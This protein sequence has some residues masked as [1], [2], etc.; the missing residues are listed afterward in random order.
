MEVVKEA[1]PKRLRTIG[2]VCVRRLRAGIGGGSA[3]RRRKFPHRDAIGEIPAYELF[4]GTEHDHG[5]VGRVG[6]VAQEIERRFVP[7]R[8][9]GVLQ[10][11]VRKGVVQTERMDCL[12]RALGAVLHEVFSSPDLRLVFRR[13]SQGQRGLIGPEHAFPPRH[14]TISLGGR[15]RSSLERTGSASSRTKRR[16]RSISSEGVRLVAVVLHGAVVFGGCSGSA[17]DFVRDMFVQTG[18][19]RKRGAD[20]AWKSRYDN[21]LGEAALRSVPAFVW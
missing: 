3:L 15:A 17:A 19:D 4:A 14:R 16:D 8:S 1:R 11:C 21:G 10:R 2:S 20:A 12:L 7:L 6:A 9:G 5:P 13:N 18:S